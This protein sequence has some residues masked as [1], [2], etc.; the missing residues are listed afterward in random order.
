[1]ADRLEADIRE[2]VSKLIRENRSMLLSREDLKRILMVA[3]SRSG[4]LREDAEPNQTTI[5]YEDVVT[6]KDADGRFRQ[7]VNANKSE[8]IAAA[9]DGLRDSTLSAQGQGTD[10][11]PGNNYS[12]AAW[13]DF[14]Q[15][16]VQS[17]A[18]AVAN[19]SGFPGAEEW[20]SSAVWTISLDDPDENAVKF[21]GI[22]EPYKVSF[23][24]G[25]RQLI[26][27]INLAS[28]LGPEAEA[29]WYSGIELEGGENA[30]DLLPSDQAIWNN[31]ADQGTLP[32]NMSEILQRYDGSWT[33]EASEDENVTIVSSVD[34]V[35]IFPGGPGEE[36]GRAR[37]VAVKFTVVQDEDGG[38]ITTE[39]ELLIQSSQGRD[40]ALVVAESD[41]IWD[42]TESWLKPTPWPQ[43]SQIGPE[44]AT[45]QNIDEWAPQVEDE[46]E[47]DDSD[48][49]ED[50]AASE[51]A[52]DAQMQTA[53]NL[54]R[55]V[56]TAAKE[57]FR[58]GLTLG[59]LNQQ[60]TYL[61]NL[62]A[63]LSDETG[64]EIQLSSTD[65]LEE[66]RNRIT[67]LTFTVSGSRSERQ[68]S[69]SWVNVGEGR[70]YIYFRAILDPSADYTLEALVNRILDI[71]ISGLIRDLS[72]SIEGVDTSTQS[73][74]GEY[75]DKIFDQ[76]M[77]EIVT[78][79]DRTSWLEKGNMIYGIFNTASAFTVSPYGRQSQEDFR[80][81]LS[82]LAAEGS[83]SQNLLNLIT[84]L[85]RDFGSA[86]AGFDEICRLTRASPDQRADAAR[87]GKISGLTT[88][89][90]LN[91]DP[92]LQYQRVL[93]Y[94]FDCSNPQAR[95][96]L[97]RLGNIEASSP[98][99][100]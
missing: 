56:V 47:D 65:L 85:D 83:R 87:L 35:S 84:R 76:G 45:F 43:W 31:A 74:Y 20:T 66:L 48:S 18:T 77:I 49:D 95:S 60:G 11:S 24:A 14:G 29:L 61:Y 36:L 50:A 79:R 55:P 9:L 68:N 71:F 82:E 33:R 46:V 21:E 94:L 86:V 13:D 53:V 19:E 52:T 70:A 99:S 15:D 26:A 10:A 5:N 22:L 34:N 8:L 12:R 91:R 100:G 72:S 80:Y 39:T 97:T 38:T 23:F 69:N 62:N 92:L 16:Y 93:L 27:Q 58:S 44:G 75:L 64:G 57:M 96:A 3:E 17:I 90:R 6:S 37:R 28:A 88:K 7:W 73:L 30:R 1:M 32:G 4:F 51:E 78:S 59:Q 67:D 63:R 98:S 89:R 41:D 81:A 54:L 25:D 2:A 42:E 40:G